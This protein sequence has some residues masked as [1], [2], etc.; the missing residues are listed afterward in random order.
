MTGERTL[1]SAMVPE[2]VY[3]AAIHPVGRYALQ[4]V[5]SDGHDTGFFTYDYLRRL[6]PCPECRLAALSRDTDLHGC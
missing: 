4:F 2:G 5:W 1:V 3:P 6:C